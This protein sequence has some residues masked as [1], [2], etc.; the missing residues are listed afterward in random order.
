[1]IQ[2]ARNLSAKIENLISKT[3]SPLRPVI[4]IIARFLL[5]VTFF[6]DSLRIL[7]QW[8]DQLV[9]LEKYR[10]FYHGANHAFLGLNVFIMCVGSAMVIMK[11]R[12]EYAVAGLFAVVISQTIGYG[13][14]FDF[15]FFLRNVSIL[16]GLLMLLA[17]SLHS[18]NSK[19][20][21]VFPGLPTISQ[22]DRSTYF[23][24]AGRILLIFLFLSFVFAGEMTPLRIAA[25]VVGLIASAMVV[26]GFKA[27][28]SALFLVL[29]LSVFNVIINN[30]WTIHHSHPTRDFV[31]YDFFQT[32]SIMGGLLLLVNLGP[33]GF[34]VDEKKKN[35]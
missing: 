17:D 20:K 25:S 33:G 26:I 9:Y 18:H 5:V 22:T 3:A 29:F 24:L 30:W 15:N 16:G 4:P 23:Q 1:M 7:A 35:Y 27:K 6:E 8:S 32:L 31:M 13:L 28:F 14:L 11:K 12:S 34:S 19:R 21:S 10:G 2:T